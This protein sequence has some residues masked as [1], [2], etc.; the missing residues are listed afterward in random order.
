MDKIINDFVKFVSEKLHIEN[1]PK[2]RVETD[3]EFATSN[4][5]FGIYYP[6]ANAFTVEVDRKSTRL[7][8]SHT[9]ISRM[10]SSA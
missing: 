4:K 5:T 1:P 8:S 3:P 7:N 9:D 2:V 10:P 6:D